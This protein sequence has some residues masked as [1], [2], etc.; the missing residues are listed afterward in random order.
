MY[1]VIYPHITTGI[2]WLYLIGIGYFLYKGVT[3]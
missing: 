1:E 3:K 2:T